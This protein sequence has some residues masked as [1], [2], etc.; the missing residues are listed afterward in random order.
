M[1]A[2]AATSPGASAFAASTV[3]KAAEFVARGREAELAGHFATAATWYKKAGVAYE[4]AG[5]ST[6]ARLWKARGADVNARGGRKMGSLHRGTKAWE[7]R[8]A[9]GKRRAGRDDSKLAEAQRYARMLKK[10]RPAGRRMRGE[11]L[12]EWQRG[13]LR[14]TLE[15]HG[16]ASHYDEVKDLL[17]PTV[18]ERTAAARKSSA[19]RYR[20]AYGSSR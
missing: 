15:R 12:H 9:L 16:L 6:R 11:E 4:K 19:A 7:K 2:R 14:S 1:T 10:W 17:L 8:P 13:Q 5:N 18:E 20:R 3:K